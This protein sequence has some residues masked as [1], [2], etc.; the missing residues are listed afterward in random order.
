MSSLNDNDDNGYAAKLNLVNSFLLK[1]KN[2]LRLI[3]S[4]DYEYVQQ[5]FQPLERLR[6]VEFT[7]DWGFRW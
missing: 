2:K 3:S 5:K 1:E 6:D 7:R 4:L